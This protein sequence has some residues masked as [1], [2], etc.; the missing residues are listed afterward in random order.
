MMDIDNIIVGNLCFLV[1]SGIFRS[2]LSN[3]ASYLLTDVQSFRS[4]PQ[5]AWSIEIYLFRCQVH[6]I[7]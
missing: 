3:I 4:W 5:P 6:L 2:V 1:R 7:R